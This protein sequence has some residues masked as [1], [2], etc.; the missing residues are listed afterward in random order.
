M[1]NSP[2]YVDKIAQLRTDAH[3]KLR[4][5]EKAWYALFCELDV[6]RDREKAAEVY[7]NVRCAARVGQ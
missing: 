3:E 7:E 2:V 1:P 5:A 4:A 6:G